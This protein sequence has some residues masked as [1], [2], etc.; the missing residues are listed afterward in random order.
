MKLKL[1][2]VSVVVF[3]FITI[4]ANYEHTRVLEKCIR[5]EKCIWALGSSNCGMCHV[6]GI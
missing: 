2:L 1:F 5:L 4:T 6:E 3:V